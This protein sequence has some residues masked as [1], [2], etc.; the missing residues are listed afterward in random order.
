MDLSA[1][2]TLVPASIALYEFCGVFVISGLSKLIDAKPLVQMFPALPV[3]FWFVAGLYEF[4]AVGMFLTDMKK[5]AL[6][7]GFIYMGGVF[8]A[9]IVLKDKNNSTMAIKSFGLI[10]VPPC[11]HSL[12]QL[13][14]IKEHNV[15]LEDTLVLGSLVAGAA[16]GL[17]VSST[18]S[19][20]KT[21]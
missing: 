14:L 10:L 21:Q 18:K 4:A 15:D 16:V 12:S 8:F 7:M 2:K 19:A 5:I 6:I 3:W 20:E 9:S 17:I 1:L 11:F 13:A